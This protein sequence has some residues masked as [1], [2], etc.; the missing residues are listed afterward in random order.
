MSDQEE[1]AALRR[2]AELEG[3]VTP[4]QSTWEK[5][6]N[7]ASGAIPDLKVAGSGLVKGL[8][9]MMAGPLDVL[10]PARNEPTFAEEVQK[11]GTAPSN[12]RQEYIN[13]IAQGAGGALIGPGALAG[14][15]K[16]LL[17]GGAAGLGAQAAGDMPGV[18]GTKY[19]TAARIAGGLAGGIGVG[20]LAAQK[21]NTGALAK[22]V[23]GDSNPLDLAAAVEL[24]QKGR[25]AGVPLNASQAMPNPSNIDN[26]VAMLTKAREGQVLTDQLREQPRQTRVLAQRLA[27]AIPGNVRG[28]QVVA[29]ST[30]EAATDA[31]TAA[32]Q[33][34]TD[35]TMPLFQQAGD[36]PPQVLNSILARVK[37]E[38]L[39]APDTNK[40]GLLNSLAGYLENAKRRVAPQSTGLL[41]SSGNPIMGP[42]QPLSM[43]E[44]NATMRSQLNN[45]KNVNLS[46]SAGDKEAIGG[47]QNIIGSIRQD[48]G[49]VSPN[50]KKANDLYSVL[51]ETTV[52]P[53]KK[54]VVGNVAGLAGALPDKEAVNKISGIL[55]AGRSPKAPATDSQILQFADAT[56]TDPTV[57]R[58]AVKTHIN[59]AIDKADQTIANSA[60]PNF[61]K[62]LEKTLLGNAA[63]QQ[64]FKDML[65]GIE[66]NADI[67]MPPNSLYKGMLNGMKILNAAGKRPGSIG[68]GSSALEEVAGASK[69]AEL[70]KFLNWN[71]FAHA[72]DKVSRYLSSDAYRKIAEGLSTPEGLVHL[73]TLAKAPIMSPAAKVAVDSLLGTQAA[74]NVPQLQN[75]NGAT[76]Q[77]ER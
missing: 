51:S 75:S 72:G 47:L 32:R 16:A 56:K 24:M 10:I 17:T 18:K 19:E 63:Q 68:P 50:F 60:S 76:E 13:S 8:G 1:L 35:A 43:N 33:A 48:L 62:A 28:N 30:Q 20:T 70:G 40:G 39:G 5:V 42:A 36:V 44:L 31:L 74:S 59:N 61:P 27:A 29:N 64:G 49:A 9:G 53:L 67:P 34:R 66:Q 37:Q 4:E 73:Q 57:F 65:N 6:K 54:G 7:F 69:T 11:F 46:S 41:D 58:D 23:L 38:A 3:R 77:G 55:A 21:K 15:G 52:D 26:A 2:M 71:A 22:E 45:A 14:V 12:K 25:K